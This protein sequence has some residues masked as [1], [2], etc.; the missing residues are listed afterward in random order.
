MHS[1]KG[2][3][4]IA[5]TLLTLPLRGQGVF[6]SPTQLTPQSVSQAD[7]SHSASGFFV[8]HLE[9][10]GSGSWP[11]ETSNS[12]A[13]AVPAIRPD[14]IKDS[15]QF[16]RYV[17]S[18]ASLRIDVI[19]R[20]ETAAKLLR[21]EREQYLNRLRDVPSILPFYIAP[22]KISG[23]T[24]TRMSSGFGMRQHPVTGNVVSHAGIDLPAPMG[25]L[26]YATADG[27]CRQ[28]INQPEGIGLAIYLSHGRG[29]QTLYGHL[30]TSWVKPGDFVV[31]GQVIGRVGASGLTTGPHL[32][33]G[34]R[35]NGQ[36]V[37]PLPY[38]FLLSKPKA[39]SVISR[40]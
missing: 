7:T 18:L 2:L 19:R 10:S 29:H 26:I 15:L 11:M 34:V 12:P 17:D 1:T 13:A 8:T 25:T 9:K 16:L 30:L 5:V 27:F 33:Y 20:K 24:K 4:F 14:P 40:K 3:L 28:R 21:S 22:D 6:T 38:C 35:Y 31:R 39:P 32:H 37:D 23:L 36:V